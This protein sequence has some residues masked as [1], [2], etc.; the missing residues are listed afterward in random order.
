MLGVRIVHR[1]HGKLQHAFLRHRPQPDHARRGLF[2][3]ANHAFQSVRPLG[4]Q[5]RYQ[6]G[7]IIHR[8]MRL[9]IDRRQNVVVISI[10]ILALDGVHRNPLIAHQ[11]GRHIILRR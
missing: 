3:P 5:N 1:H 11:A 4:V 10:V 2:R 9:M 7:A 8:D 6:V